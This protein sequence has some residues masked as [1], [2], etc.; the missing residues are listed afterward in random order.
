MAQGVVRAL[1][2]IGAK[3]DATTARTADTE[4]KL[5]RIA[6]V[7]ALAAEF[8]EQRA[9]RVAM[10]A[11]NARRDERLQAIRD[12]KPIRP[13]TPAEMAAINARHY[14]RAR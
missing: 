6:P 4:A 1:Q 11:H 9:V 7:L 3:V 10:S 5:E 8:K 12:G 14:G 2:R 13:E